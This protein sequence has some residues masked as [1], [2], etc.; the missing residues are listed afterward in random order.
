VEKFIP[1]IYEARRNRS[2]RAKEEIERAPLGILTGAFI[3]IHG[4][5]RRSAD[6]N[7]RA[8]ARR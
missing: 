6:Q 1:K 8:N 4:K 3:S 2:A 7:G 5:L